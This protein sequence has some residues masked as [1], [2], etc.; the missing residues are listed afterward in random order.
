MAARPRPNTPPTHPAPQIIVNQPLMKN[1]NLM[2]RV[3]N[4]TSVVTKISIPLTSVMASGDLRIE[5]SFESDFASGTIS[6]NLKWKPH[7]S[8]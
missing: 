3:A 4:S 1:T 6:F 8:S 5:E 2:F 7:V